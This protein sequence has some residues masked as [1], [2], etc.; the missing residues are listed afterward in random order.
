LFVTDIVFAPALDAVYVNVCAVDVPRG[1]VTL[2][3]VNVPP[4]AV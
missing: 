1:I 4:A 3:G 2:V